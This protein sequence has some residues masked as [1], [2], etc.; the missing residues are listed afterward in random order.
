MSEN[1]QELT[2]LQQGICSAINNHNLDMLE[3]LI[4]RLNSVNDPIFEDYPALTMASNEC[5]YEGM[6]LLIQKGAN[7]NHQNEAMKRAPLHYAAAKGDVRATEILVKNGADTNVMDN[8]GYTPLFLSVDAQSYDTTEFL[9]K[10]KANPNYKHPISEEPI[11]HTAIYRHNLKIIQLLTYYGADVHCQDRM[12]R[13][14]LEAATYTDYWPAV[15]LLVDGYNADV[16]KRGY[17]GGTALLYA[18]GNNNLKSIEIIMR[19]NPDIHI[20]DGYGTSPVNLA[21]GKEYFDALKKMLDM[22]KEFTDEEDKNLEKYLIVAARHNHPHVINI[23][24]PYCKNIDFKDADGKTAIHHAA[25]MGNFEAFEALVSHN[26]KLDELDNQNRTPLM[27]AVKKTF[28][29]F[30]NDIDAEFYQ[31][32]ILKRSPKKESIK[33]ENKELYDLAEK[34]LEGADKIALYLLR[35]GKAKIDIYDNEGKTPLQYAVEGVRERP[36][37]DMH[38]SR[39]PLHLI[40]F[41]TAKN[42]LKLNSPKIMDILIERGFNPNETDIGQ[43]NSLMYAL[44]NASADMIRLLIDAGANIYQQNNSGDSPD[45][46]IERD[47]RYKE[48]A[49]IIKDRQHKEPA[50]SNF[51]K[52]RF[53]TRINRSDIISKLMKKRNEH[54]NE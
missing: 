51:K 19:K 49:K 8:M 29:D 33:S 50:V 54:Q 47:E 21:L 17:H 18:V 39:A 12:D 22:K 48:V 1:N 38:L 52:T 4:S 13:T 25:S 23:I 37:Y 20:E 46:L 3:V 41:D 15:S 11:L 53:R 31:E 6:E 43:N 40:D 36:A 16:D 27:D 14:A 42:A 9:L 32:R 45:K 28:Y 5:F 34:Q 35:Q 26:A 2:P 10:N 24:A 44:R 7:V 30:V